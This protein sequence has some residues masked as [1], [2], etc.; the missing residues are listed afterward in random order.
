MI[1]PLRDLPDASDASVEVLAELYG[2]GP[3][4]IAEA[5]WHRNGCLLTAL[6]SAR[7]E[8]CHDQRLGYLDEDR[9][10]PADKFATSEDVNA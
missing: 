8:R 2:A 7:V 1:A 4:Y 10:V 5:S 3:T 6:W 9:P